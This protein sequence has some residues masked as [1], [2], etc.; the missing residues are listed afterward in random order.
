ME[1]ITANEFVRIA[2]YHSLSENNNV[3][4]FDITP[5][6]ATT[7]K[8]ALAIK[9]PNAYINTLIYCQEI[10]VRASIQSV[11]DF[12]YP[13]TVLDGFTPS[14]KANSDLLKALWQQP[15]RELSLYQ[16]LGASAFWR[17]RGGV[18]LPNRLKSGAYYYES[19][20]SIMRENS[21]TYELQNDEKLG[22]SLTN[23]TF[24]LLAGT[25]EI[26]V[27]ANWELVH[28]LYD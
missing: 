28:I 23:N 24:G 19:L 13:E 21:N 18:A 17:L 10:D 27:S 26:L 5:A 8:T 7:V 15:R 11:A 14:V 3:N 1:R 2:R 20:L 16:K 9:Y 22:I 25:D 12:V 6:T 4:I